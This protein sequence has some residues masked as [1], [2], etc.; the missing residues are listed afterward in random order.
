MKRSNSLAPA[1]L[2][3]ALLCS[4]TGSSVFGAA[5]VTQTPDFGAL[6]ND[7]TG[8]I[9]ASDFT[10]GSATTLTALTVWI[11]DHAQSNSLD[12]VANNFSGILGWAIYS[13]IGNL[14]G[15]LLFSGSDAAPSVSSTG[16]INGNLREVFEVNAV[17]SGSPV[18]AA[19]TYW[20][21]IRDGAWGGGNDGTVV[22]WQQSS[23]V[24]GQT[25][26]DSINLVNPV[27]SS[28]TGDSAFVLFDNV[29]DVPEPST[30][31]LSAL[32]VAGLA[33]LRRRMN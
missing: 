27:F 29:S 4:L 1:L 12:G 6:N 8:F 33:L 5:V 30:M 7:I 13:N 20:L 18:L 14:P 22:G 25:L 10:L 32:G 31:V 9:V 23:P 26:V 19:G 16:L 28:R 24:V 15:T 21:A 3:M 17:L 11:A 2:R